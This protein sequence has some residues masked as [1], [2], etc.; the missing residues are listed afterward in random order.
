MQG[1]P[2]LLYLVPCTLGVTV[3]LAYARGELSEMWEGDACGALLEACVG[4]G[5]VPRSRLPM[6]REETEEKEAEEGLLS[7]P[8]R[9]V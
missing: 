4:Q 7:R 3:A 1:Q 6:I 2:A 9:S 5:C 8:S